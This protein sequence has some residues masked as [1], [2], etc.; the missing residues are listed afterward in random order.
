M[1][2]AYRQFNVLNVVSFHYSN[3]PPPPPIP[4]CPLD[5]DMSLYTF[6]TCKGHLGPRGKASKNKLKDTSFI[7]PMTYV[8]IL[9][10]FR[11]HAQKEIR[12]GFGNEEDSY[13]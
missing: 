6:T 11:T 8:T 7:F 9:C 1:Q 10:I 13:P 2:Y 4:R 5:N 3:N 12:Y